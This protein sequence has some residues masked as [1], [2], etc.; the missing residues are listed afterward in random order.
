MGGS[1]Y[2]WSE[3][4]DAVHTAKVQAARARA[5]LRALSS[6]LQEAGDGPRIPRVTMESFLT[7]SDLFFSNPIVDFV[8][9]KRIGTMAKSIRTAHVSLK[10]ITAALRKSK[11]ETAVALNCA[12]A[13]R[14]EFV[15]TLA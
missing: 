4:H 6:I 14:R 10:P 1:L 15:E 12:R 7:L 8:V 13:A 5:S 2:T 3:K 9:L 11:K